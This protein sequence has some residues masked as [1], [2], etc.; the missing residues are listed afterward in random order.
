MLTIVYSIAFIFRIAYNIFFVIVS[1]ITVTYTVLSLCVDLV[2]IAMPLLYVM[3]MHMVDVMKKSGDT[4]ETEGEK[5]PT[6]M[7]YVD[8]LSYLQQERADSELRYVTEAP[9]MR[10]NTTD[11]LDRTRTIAASSAEESR[12]PSEK[13]RMTDPGFFF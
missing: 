8:R 9:Y 3:Y 13:V 11:D 4:E 12:L 5:S 1:G 2:C 10:S 7:N 6:R